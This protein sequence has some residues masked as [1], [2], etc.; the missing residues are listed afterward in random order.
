MN[1]EE[2]ELLERTLKLSEDNH[3]ILKKMQRTARLALIWG[4]VKVLIIAIPVVLGYLY[5]API[6]EEMVRGFHEM[7]AF[8]APSSFLR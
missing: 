5:F 7:R 3:K 4:F 8:L 6:F 2:K 1:P